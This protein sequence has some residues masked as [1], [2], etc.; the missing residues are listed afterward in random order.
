MS[1]AQKARKRPEPRAEPRRTV[2]TEPEPVVVPVYFRWRGVFH[3]LTAAVLLVFAA[4]II[5][6][7]VVAVWLT[8][9]G[10]A[11]YRQRRVG[12]NGRIFTL[13]KIRSMCVDAEAE[14]G[15]VWTVNHRDPRIT[16]LGRFL[17]YT[18][19]DELP[20]L[21]NVINGEMALVG[22]RPERPEFT[23]ALEDQIPGYT[24]RL[25]VPP[26]ITGLAQ[27]NLPPDSDL[28]SVR[29]K[30]MLDLEYIRAGS[31][32]LD[33][34]IILCTFFRLAGIRA[35]YLCRLARVER[36]TPDD[37]FAVAG[38]VEAHSAVTD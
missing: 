36:S 37:P 26:G 11:I 38:L 5:L 25:R 3:W 8:S 14:T 27:L 17:R 22:P 16:P 10:P 13:Y 35:R 19:L 23:E 7:T 34:S 30:L 24:E 31:V 9:P 32:K 33:C 15:P 1:I 21:V 20:Q 29:R 4:P 12:K 6:F 2:V 18:H 28:D